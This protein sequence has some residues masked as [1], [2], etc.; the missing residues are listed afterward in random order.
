M[1]P[2]ITNNLIKMFQ[3]LCTEMLYEK[4]I[5]IIDGLYAR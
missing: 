2:D 5:K 1:L 4:T 3:N